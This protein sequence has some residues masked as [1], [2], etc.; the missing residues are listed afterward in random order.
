MLALAAANLAI[1]VRGPFEGP[2]PAAE[3]ARSA[4]GEPLLE[5]S[6]PEI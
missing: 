4:L 2:L 5:A 1:F 6:R 3:A